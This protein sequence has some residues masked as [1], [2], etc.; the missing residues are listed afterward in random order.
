[1]CRQ[2]VHEKTVE[3]LNSSLSAIVMNG[4]QKKKNILIW[5][6]KKNLDTQLDKFLNEEA[7]VHLNTRAV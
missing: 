5:G 4:V 6:K 3:L 1:M 2:L 7:S